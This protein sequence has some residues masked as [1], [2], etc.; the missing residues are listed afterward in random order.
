MQ[1]GSKRP[2]S[3]GAT[4]DCDHPDASRS[5]QTASKLI[6][7]VPTPSLHD[8]ALLNNDPILR[9]KACALKDNVTAAR[10]K[11]V[12]LRNATIAGI[13]NPELLQGVLAQCSQLL[14]QRSVTEDVDSTKKKFAE[15]L[16]LAATL[17]RALDH[18]GTKLEEHAAT[19]L[20]NAKNIE[21]L[22]AGDNWRSSERIS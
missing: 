14:G 10:A 20:K 15:T 3:A 6:M 19:E 22:E 1:H 8:N 11:S 21:Q 7:D 16:E 5:F 4:P 17:T 12:T 18:A 9:L 2:Y 13:S